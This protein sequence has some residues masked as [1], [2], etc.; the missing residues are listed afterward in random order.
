[1]PCY[2]GA[3]GEEEKKSLLMMVT[4]PRVWGWGRRQVSAFT[5][6]PLAMPYLPPWQPVS[7]GSLSVAVEPDQRR[8][9]IPEL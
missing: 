8:P 5:A 6:G 1:M 4:K 3:D 9:R 7:V 2:H